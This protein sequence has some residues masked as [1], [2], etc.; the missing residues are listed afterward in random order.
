MKAGPSTLGRRFE[1]RIALFVSMFGFLSLLSDRAHAQIDRN[2]TGV[3]VAVDRPTSLLIRY[4]ELNGNAFFSSEALFCTQL[5]ANGAC[6]PGT[7]LGRLPAR[8]DRGSVPLAGNGAPI[9]PPI[10]PLKIS[11]NLSSSS[12]AQSA[13][14]SLTDFMT[15]PMSVIRSAVERSRTGAFSDFFYVRQF[16]PVAGADIGAGPGQNV[17]VSVTCRLTGGTARTPLSLSRVELFGEEKDSI[18]SD[19]D[20]GVRFIRLTPANFD[21]VTSKHASPTLALDAS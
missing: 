13:S 1:M 16:T 12:S 5:L 10:Q 6:A 3:N 2:P 17:F 14:N 20:R 7:I 8:L 21:E 18:K 11:P 9:T 19:E 4:S 15:I